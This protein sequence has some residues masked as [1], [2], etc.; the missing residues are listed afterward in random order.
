MHKI[1]IEGIDVYT[2][3][4]H[5]LIQQI[6]KKCCAVK[7]ETYLIKG[8]KRLKLNKHCKMIQHKMREFDHYKCSGL[9]LAYYVKPP[10][11]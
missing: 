1:Y 4:F 9:L 11:T 8:H 5:N 10:K 6:Q 2:A 7:M 3:T